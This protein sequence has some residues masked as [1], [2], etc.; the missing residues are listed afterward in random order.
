MYLT[1]LNLPFQTMLLGMEACSVI[2][3]RMEKLAGGGPG[4]FVEAN[5]MI[6]EKNS[7][8]HE[9]AATLMGGGSMDKVVERY[10]THVRANEARL[11]A[12]R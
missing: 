4:A 12:D 10:R 3:L 2:G 1:W 11:Q 8:L 6:V 7:A 9:A 5:R